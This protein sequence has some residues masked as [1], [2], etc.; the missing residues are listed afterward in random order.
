[1]FVLLVAQR[2]ENGKEKGVSTPDIMKK[3]KFP[4]LLMR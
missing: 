2:P 1:V 3:I 4:A